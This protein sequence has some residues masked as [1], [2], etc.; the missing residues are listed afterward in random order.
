ML[1]CHVAGPEAIPEHAASDGES[2]ERVTPRRRKSSQ[3]DKAAAVAATVAPIHVGAPTIHQHEKESAEWHQKRLRD[4]CQ[5]VGLRES[6]L[7]SSHRR[8]VR[9]GM[10]Q[11]ESS[12]GY[13]PCLKQR[14]IILCTD[15]L[16]IADAEAR[17]KGVYMS[18]AD[19]GC[20]HADV[21]CCDVMQCE[22]HPI[23]LSHHSML[24]HPIMS[25]SIMSHPLSVMPR[26]DPFRRCLL[27]RTQQQIGMRV[28]HRDSRQESGTRIPI[29]S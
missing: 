17:F 21:I 3:W 27:Q 14:R 5:Q 1:M 29:R 20:W 18:C 12:I 25:H 2:E 11:K 26:C 22:S 10:L 24:S 6:A 13:I 8:F 23:M 15:L 28:L 16:L 7:L 4:V 19:A 9:E